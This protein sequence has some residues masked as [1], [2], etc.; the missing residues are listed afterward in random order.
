[1]FQDI[2]IG[3]LELRVFERWEMLEHADSFQV[4]ESGLDRVWGKVGMLSDFTGTELE[5]PYFVGKLEEGLKEEFAM[6]D[7]VFAP[8]LD[9]GLSEEMGIQGRG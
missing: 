3:E 7:A 8:V 4:F 5:F 9:V 6:F 2:A 1:M